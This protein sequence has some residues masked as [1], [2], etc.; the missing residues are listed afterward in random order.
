MINKQIKETVN[1][2]WNET[3]FHFD[4]GKLRECMFEFKNRTKVKEKLDGLRS[5]RKASL[6]IE[7]KA[8]FFSKTSQLPLLCFLLRA[9]MLSR[10]NRVWLFVTL[11]TVAHLAPLSMGFYSHEHWSE[12]PC[13]PLG[14][15]SWPRNQT[16]ASFVSCI[17]KWVIYL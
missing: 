6:Q 5:F 8:L 9:C 3:L 13:R 1:S 12:V 4:N 7:T 10:F 11:W 2:N 17:G 15:S 14:G 16:C